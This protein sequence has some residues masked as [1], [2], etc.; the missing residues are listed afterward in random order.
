MFILTFYSVDSPGERCGYP[1]LLRYDGDVPYLY[2]SC[3]RW[4]VPGALLSVFLKTKGEKKRRR[5]KLMRGGGGPL[6]YISVIW[7]AGNLDPWMQ[8][9][10][11]LMRVIATLL[12]TYLQGHE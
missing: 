10:I 11:D 3:F 5:R 6:T 4:E 12:L 2:R 9:C 7:E 1:P 8:R